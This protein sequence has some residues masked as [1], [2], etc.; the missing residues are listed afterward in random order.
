[1]KTASGIL[2]GL[3]GENMPKNVGEGVCN[4]CGQPY[5]IFEMMHLFGDKKGET[6]TFKKGCICED[7]EIARAAQQARNNARMRKALHHLKNLDCTPQYNQDASFEGF[8]AQNVGQETAKNYLKQYAR[9]FLASQLTKNNVL[10]TGTTGLGKTHLAIATMREIARSGQKTIAFL[11]MPTLFTRLKNSFDNKDVNE[12][13]LLTALQNVD[14][15]VLDDIGAEMKSDW[16][17]DIL[18][19]IVEARQGKHTIYTTNFSSYELEKHV[20]ERIFSRMIYQTHVLKLEG[21]D[22]RK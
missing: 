9:L 14:F 13:E 22:M 19:Q 6:F 1:M 18:F 8:N 7:L 5:N 11:T 12:S 10:I 16:R 2:R 17:K 21:K 3:I 4:E 15:L 20:G